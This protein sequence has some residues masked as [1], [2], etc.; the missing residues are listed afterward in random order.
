MKTIEVTEW[1]NQQRISRLQ[2]LV[3]VLC[4]AAAA[5]EGFDTQSIGF[6][7]PSVIHEWHLAPKDF[8]P[9]FVVGLLG[10]LVGCLV[11]APLADWI[12]RKK[13]LV[14][15]SLWFG[16][17]SLLT[18]EAS[19]MSTLSI[20]RFLTDAGLGGGMANA[21]ALT[22]EY[23]P[24]RKR[25]AMT[26]VMFCGFPLGASLGGFLAAALIPRYGWPS[27]FVLGGIL[28]ILLAI[29]L[30]FT[31]PESIRYLVL[32]RRAQERVAAILRR[33]NPRASFAQ[34][35]TFA[36]AEEQ[37]SGLTV[38][39]LFREGRAAGTVLLWMMFF[40]N[41]LGLFLLTS[42]LPTLLHDAGL[43]ISMAVVIISVQQGSG[44]IASIAAGPILERRSCVSLLLPLFV[45]SGLGI[46]AIGSV[47]A[48]VP[49][50]LAAAA[51][52]GIGSV[53]GQ[54]VA[55]AL[56][57]V[58]YPTYIRAT[59]VGWALGIGRIGAIV[60]PTVGGLMLAL[61]WTTSSIFLFGAVPSFIAAAAALTMMWVEGRRE[62]TVAP[63]SVTV[64]R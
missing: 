9:A 60:G 49:L 29:V 61:H 50:I 1:I 21:I 44:V 26:V 8:T 10:L 5:L 63:A 62:T 64:A 52:S 15:T 57:A 55:N 4:A 22:S 14:G 3:L 27:V 34:G 20:L 6:V 58:Y 16:V 38:G 56:A 48:S 41:L 32:K 47:G 40:M 45:L 13:L 36:I 54:N 28:P 23:F 46:A 59:G 12:G 24:A 7:A 11:I 53:T 30:V 17:F 43:S 37:R 19:T 35:T 51:I 18:A 31:L 33:I 2:I 39:H 42:W 25:A